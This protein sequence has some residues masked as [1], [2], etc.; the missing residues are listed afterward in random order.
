MGLGNLSQAGIYRRILCEVERGNNLRSVGVLK[1]N[2]RSSLATET[3]SS[4]ITC[5][6][7]NV[8]RM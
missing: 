8:A 6:C 5:I 4:L 2:F 3:V 7:L 1:L